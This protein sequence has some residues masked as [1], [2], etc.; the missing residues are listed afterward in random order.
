ME[1]AFLC[2]L[3]SFIIIPSVI[4]VKDKIKHKILKKRFKKKVDN[5]IFKKKFKNYSSN[6]CCTFCLENYKKDK[7]VQLYCDHIFH[8]KCLFK[9]LNLH[10]KCPLCNISLLT[11]NGKRI[12][13]CTLKDF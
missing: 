6:E 4:Y 8:K 10:L 9:W 5:F 7:C 12:N 2:T 11:K 13:E 1:I 3:G